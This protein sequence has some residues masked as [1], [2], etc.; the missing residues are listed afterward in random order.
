M[1]QKWELRIHVGYI[2]KMDDNEIK[3]NESEAALDLQYA[4]IRA[5]NYVGR[6]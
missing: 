4:R 1:V 2:T 5:L 6:S 3:G